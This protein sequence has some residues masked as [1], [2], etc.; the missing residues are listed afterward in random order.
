MCINNEKSKIF[1]NVVLNNIILNNVTLTR[2]NN[3]SY[4]SEN[5]YL[6]KAR[7]ISLARDYR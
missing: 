2:N 7:N 1:F 5:K 3:L 6:N 4:A